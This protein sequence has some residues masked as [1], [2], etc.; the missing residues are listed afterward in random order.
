VEIPVGFALTVRAEPVGT[1]YLIGSQGGPPPHPR[2]NR[3]INN[4]RLSA[5]QSDGVTLIGTS[6][7]GGL[8]AP[9]TLQSIQRPASGVV[10]IKVDVSTFAEDIQRYRLVF[11]L[12]G[13]TTTFVPNSYTLVRGFEISGGLF[14]IQLSDDFRL[15]L[16]PTGATELARSPVE[17]I[18]S[19][20]ST[21]TNPS[22]LILGYEGSSSSVNI[23]RVIHMFDFVAGAWVEINAAPSNTREQVFE[24]N[25]V[26]PARFVAGDGTI[27]ARLTLTQTGPIF[28][29][30]WEVTTDQIYWRISQ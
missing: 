25:A 15:K 4:L 26:N 9:E 17:F 29:Y 2:D 18:A 1:Q 10:S 7:T 14:G 24:F 27:R 30:P 19:T 22:Q 13:A 6:N 12:D 11:L 23:R 20:T 21:I 28:T 8:G 16:A 5:Y 3:F